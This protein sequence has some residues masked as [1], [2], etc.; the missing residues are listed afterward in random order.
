MAEGEKLTPL[1]KIS[2]FG[3]LVAGVYMFLSFG[4]DLSEQE[5]TNYQEQLLKGCEFM[6]SELMLYPEASCECRTD[7]VMS[8]F[9]KADM[10]TLISI[11][12]QAKTNFQVIMQMPQE[13]LDEIFIAGGETFDPRFLAGDKI[14]LAMQKTDAELSFTE[15][16][17]FN[18]AVYSGELE[19]E[20]KSVDDFSTLA[21]ED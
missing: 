1:V 13:E 4:S 15:R 7:F 21:R 19:Q 11:E 5:R 18:R 6:A 3:V 8:K 10:D 17:I 12:K 16:Y 20:C 14:N 2:F 9:N